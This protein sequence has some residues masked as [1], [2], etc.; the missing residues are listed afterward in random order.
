MK[1]KKITYYCYYYFMQ[2][3]DSKT[4]GLIDCE[5]FIDF[6]MQVCEHKNN[7]KN[8]IHKKMMILI[9]IKL[10]ITKII[11]K[12]TENNGAYNNN[13]NND[14][15]NKKNDRIYNNISSNLI[16]EINFNESCNVLRQK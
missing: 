11:K 6:C 9:I 5:E 14:I 2:R 12:S 10:I 15:F 7:N 1:N 13:N 16:K 3:M 4:D 8:N